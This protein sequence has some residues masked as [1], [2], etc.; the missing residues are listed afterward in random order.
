MIKFGKIK[1][2]LLETLEDVQV[3]ISEQPGGKVSISF[4]GGREERILTLKVLGAD[5]RDYNFFD[6]TKKAISVL[7][8]AADP[9][10][11]LLSIEDLFVLTPD[12]KEEIKAI[13]SLLNRMA[14]K[15]PEDS[16]KDWELNSDI[17]E[18]IKNEAEGSRT[19]TKVSNQEF[20]VWGDFRKRGTMAKNLKTGEIKQIS[21]SGYI[22]NDITVRKAIAQ[23]FGL[24]SFR[25]S[26]KEAYT[27]VPDQE[28]IYKVEIDNRS[29]VTVE[30]KDI[31][32][33]EDALAKLQSPID[34][35]EYLFRNTTFIDPAYPNHLA[36]LLGRV[37]QDHGT[38]GFVD[39]LRA[40]N[41]YL[42]EQGQALS[43]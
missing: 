21:Y 14:D 1:E 4:K 39:L 41:F 19:K 33:F 6:A 31:N 12:D 40:F 35:L 17:G 22:S 42:Y 11:V 30:V 24:P 18:S 13:R 25:S 16:Q 38:K 9:N 34:I 23:K 7:R 37:W 2:S 5:N 10:E 27:A 15:A 20:E 8:D 3:S 28:T 26:V 43:R 32:E 29:T 36:D